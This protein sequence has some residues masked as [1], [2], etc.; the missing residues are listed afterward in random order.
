MRPTGNCWFF[1]LGGLHEM[2]TISLKGEKNT[3]KM[4]EQMEMRAGRIETDEQKHSSE[5]VQEG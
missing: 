2:L 5:N 4:L 3:G 1:V